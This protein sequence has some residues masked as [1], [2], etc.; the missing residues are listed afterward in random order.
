M[1]PDWGVVCVGL[2]CIAVNLALLLLVVLE[3][4]RVAQQRRKREDRDGE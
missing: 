1:G 4:T 3:W 2:F